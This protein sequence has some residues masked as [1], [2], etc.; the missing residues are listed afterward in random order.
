MTTQYP[1]PPSRDPPP[2]LPRRRNVNT[3]EPTIPAGPSTSHEDPSVMDSIKSKL[4]FTHEHEEGDD[5]SFDVIGYWAITA[6]SWLFLLAIPLLLFPR[7]LAFLAQSNND[8]SFNLASSHKKG[9]HYDDLTPLEKL[10]A[11]QLGWGCVGVAVVLACIIASPNSPA[12][13]FPPLSSTTSL[14]PPVPALPPTTALRLSILLTISS[15]LSLSAFFIYNNQ[16]VG[17]AVSVGVGMGN[18]ILGIWGFWVGLF[19]FGGKISKK[20]G[21]DKRTSAFPFKN[22]NAASVQKSK[23]KAERGFH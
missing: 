15:L 3:S 8:P 23:W 18:A 1:P 4:P 17:Q 21:A 10:L 6:L 22:K 14:P 19:G 12:P 5:D 13:P 11:Q 2:E 16:S 20:T 9:Q 7:L